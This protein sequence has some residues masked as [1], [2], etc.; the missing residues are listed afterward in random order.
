MNLSYNKPLEAV[1]LRNLA[2]ELYIARKNLTVTYITENLVQNSRF[3]LGLDELKGGA[4]QQFIND[5]RN[6]S[7][8]LLSPA[9]KKP[10]PTEKEW[11]KEWRLLY[12][13]PHRIVRDLS[14]DP[15]IIESRIIEKNVYYYEI[16]LK[17]SVMQIILSIIYT[18]IELFGLGI[19]N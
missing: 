13:P 4:A 14:K 6:R 7:R 18:H 19:D 1:F 8:P 9:R 10:E 5:L 15:I 12:L 11:L 16:Q 3:E 2:Y 17:N